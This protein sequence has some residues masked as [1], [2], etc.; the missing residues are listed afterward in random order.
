M[1]RGRHNEWDENGD[2]GLPDW[3]LETPLPHIDIVAEHEVEY[4]EHQER[5]TKRPPT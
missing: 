5:A 4:E 2:Q 1:D 3:N